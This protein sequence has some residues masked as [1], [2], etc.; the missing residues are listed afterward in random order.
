MTKEEL[1][2]EWLMFCVT[3]PTPYEQFLQDRL[4]ERMAS[5]KIMAGDLGKAL[6]KIGDLER[7]LKSKT[8][9][10]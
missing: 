1:K 7:E 3:N 10:L 4:I 2:H 8:S 9:K 6:A 5:N